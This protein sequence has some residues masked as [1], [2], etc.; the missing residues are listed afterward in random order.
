MGGANESIHASAHRLSFESSIG[1][2]VGQIAVDTFII[3]SE[4]LVGP[5]SEQ[6][7]AGI[8]DMKF[9]VRFPSWKWCGD[10]DA[11][12]NGGGVGM[13]L[14][15]D[16][17]MKGNL[18][19]VT[20]IPGTANTYDLGGGANLTLTDFVMLDGQ[21]GRMAPGYPQMFNHGG[22]QIF[23]F[24][25]PKFIS[26]AEYDPLLRQGWHWGQLQQAISDFNNAD[27]AAISTSIPGSSAS[28]LT[29]LSIFAGLVFFL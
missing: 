1:G 22:S 18:S 6:W 4:G 3:T 25:F 7:N 14:E 27:G 5:E 17:K 8:G 26:S 2:N 15:L 10:P 23:R 29:A 11:N 9:N 20:L 12:C 28:I 16:I 13:F 24:R 19:Q 21:E